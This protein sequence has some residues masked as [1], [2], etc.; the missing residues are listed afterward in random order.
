M[1]D[2]NMPLL[3]L[4][5]WP[6]RS[7]QGQEV[8]EMALELGYRHIDTAQMY[9]NEADVGRGIASSNVARDSLY[10]VTKVAQDRISD[11]TY[12]DSARR[13][14][15]NLGLTPDLFL[16]HWPPRG[17]ETEAVIDAMQEIHAQGLTRSIGVSNFNVPMLE[18]AVAHA[19]IPIVTNQV[20][21]HAVMDQSRLKATADRLGV[22]LT[23]YCPIARGLVLKD[24]TIERIAAET[25]HSPAQV[26]LRWALQNGVAAICMSTR[27]ENLAAN[28][29]VLN[30][31]LSEA[32][33]TQITA[34]NAQKNRTVL[35]PDWAPDWDA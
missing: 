31:E 2:L 29:E 16:I 7:D 24:P 10:V 14:Q 8:V 11:G 13:S 30:M 27:R 3:G 17:I 33:M 12:L 6:L 23:A 25:G 20:E 22:G 4:G 26:A 15:D 32:H 35:M 34:L 18:R 9:E 21:Y 5:T 1:T 28:F 19:S